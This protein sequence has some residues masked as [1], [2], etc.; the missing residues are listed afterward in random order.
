MEPSQ[1]K[2]QQ[3]DERGREGKWEFCGR[4]RSDSNQ[5]NAAPLMCR[6]KLNKVRLCSDFAA[7][8][9]SDGVLA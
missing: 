7:T 8:A 4:V 1:K 2:V 3:K 5:A 9:D 6:T